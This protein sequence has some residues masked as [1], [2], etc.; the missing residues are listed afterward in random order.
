MEKAEM[1][2]AHKH[3]YQ[4]KLLKWSADYVLQNAEFRTTNMDT[5]RARAKYPQEIWKKFNNEHE[6][7]SISAKKK[8][9]Q[10]T[11]NELYEQA[12]K[13]YFDGIR[14]IEQE[15]QDSNVSHTGAGAVVN[16]QQG[17]QAEVSAAE[18]KS[19][20]QTCH[21]ECLSEIMQNGMIFV[22]DIWW[23]CIIMHGMLTCSNCK[24]RSWC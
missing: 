11:R 6:L 9:E 1:A 2:D 8:D 12:E 18:L 4:F 16:L 15:E 7:V 17:M 19:V 20:V 21:V 5:L 10:K 23:Q 14:M 13:L 22:I 24:C 3:D